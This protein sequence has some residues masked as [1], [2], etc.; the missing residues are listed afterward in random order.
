MAWMGSCHD[1]M[2]LSGPQA[3]EAVPNLLH[4]IFL[5]IQPKK[6]TLQYIV[7]PSN[8]WVPEMATDFRTS[9]TSQEAFNTFHIHLCMWYHPPLN[10][11]FWMFLG[12]ICN[13]SIIVLSK[14]TS[15]IP[16]PRKIV[17]HFFNGERL[18]TTL[19]P[20]ADWKKIL[21]RLEDSSIFIM[22][23]QEIPASVESKRRFNRTR[24]ACTCCRASNC[25]SRCR[26]ASGFRIQVVA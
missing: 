5:E 16:P 21:T 25:W 11:G 10:Y 3:S 26:L 13:S 9:V 6:C 1:M 4:H 20:T 17:P 23:R 8:R 19:R 24:L 15:K 22:L 7:D 18:A 12:G 2:A 14:F